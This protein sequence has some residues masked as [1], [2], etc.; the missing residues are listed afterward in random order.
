MFGAAQTSFRDSR[1]CKAVMDN[2]TQW[3]A[4]INAKST[5]S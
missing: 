1:M 3:T 5:I 2:Y 4:D